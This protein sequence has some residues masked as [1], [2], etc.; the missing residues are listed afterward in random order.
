MLSTTWFG[1]SGHVIARVSWIRLRGLGPWIRPCPPQPL[2]PVV[3]VAS[4]CPGCL[5]WRV[6]LTDSSACVADPAQLQ[7]VDP[8]KLNGKMLIDS[9]SVGAFCN[10]SHVQ[11]R[12]WQLTGCWF[13]F[14]VN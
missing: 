2:G 14:E 7:R 5:T 4:L 1:V 8:E 3:D 12:F 10:G 6:Y 9:P 13:A 11:K